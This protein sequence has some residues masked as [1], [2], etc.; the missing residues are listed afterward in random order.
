MCVY[1][2]GAV[3]VEKTSLTQPQR[4]TASIRIRRSGHVP[5]DE[6]VTGNLRSLGTHKIITQEV[7]FA[8]PKGRL[9]PTRA[10][11]RI[12]L[13]CF[14]GISRQNQQPLP[15]RRGRTHQQTLSG[16]LSLKTN[17]RARYFT[18]GEP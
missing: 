13:F 3:S 7:E 18:S 4:T 16:P 12:A 11:E 8:T 9:P 17:P 15:G 10:L 1:P 14:L 5:P 6:R 2:T